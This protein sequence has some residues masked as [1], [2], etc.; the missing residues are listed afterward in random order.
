MPRTI[1]SMRTPACEAR[2][3]A[4]ITSGST[5]EFIFATMRA[6]CPSRASAVSRS[7]AASVFC[8]RFSGATHSLRQRCCFEKPVR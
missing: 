1:K 6:S 2:Y 8:R 5:S 3:S 7:M 4:R